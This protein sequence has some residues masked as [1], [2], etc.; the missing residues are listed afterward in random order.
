MCAPGIGGNTYMQLQ[1][2]KL[3]TK[4]QASPNWDANQITDV[5]P[6]KYLWR[7]L[8]FQQFVK[9]TPEVYGQK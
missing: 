1:L 7:G 3:L 6:E 8:Q 5:V 9:D 2:S 4:L